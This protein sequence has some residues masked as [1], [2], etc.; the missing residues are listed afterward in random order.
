VRCIPVSTGFSFWQQTN[1]FLLLCLL[2]TSSLGWSFNGHRVVAAIAETYLNTSGRFGINTWLQGRSMV[3]VSIDPDAYVSEN[4][5]AW[6]KTLHYVNLPDYAIEFKMEEGCPIPCVVEAVQNYSNLITKTRPSGSFTRFPPNPVVFLIHFFSDLHQ[7]L[8]VAYGS[9]LGGNKK[10]CTFMGQNLNLHS[11]WDGGWMYPTNTTW[12]ALA[13]DLVSETKSDP[14]SREVW[15]QTLDPIDIAQ[16]S[17]SL[18]RENVYTFLPEEMPVNA[19][20]PY[21]L[22]QPYLKRSLPVIRQR[23][24]QAGVRLAALLN[25]LFK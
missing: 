11:F 19:T 13:E 25:H 3:N 10:T 8:H 5:S 12:E 14:F 6:S 9:D 2:F 21:R 1:M 24:M 7:P 4:G 16:E 22:G 17:F 23:L 18:V 15:A 20:G